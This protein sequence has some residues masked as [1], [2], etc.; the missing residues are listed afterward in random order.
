MIYDAWLASADA[1]VGYPMV[2][3]RDIETGK[4]RATRQLMGGR[5]KS[6]SR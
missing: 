6:P 1:M 2:N 5:L 4:V 3:L